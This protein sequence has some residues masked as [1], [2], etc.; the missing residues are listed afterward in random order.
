MK[1]KGKM[2]LGQA[3][4]LVVSPHKSLLLQQQVLTNFQH[5]LQLLNV[6]SYEIQESEFVKIL[7]SLVSHLNDLHR[8]SN[9]H[10][11]WKE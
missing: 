8:K 10:W 7:G 2:P 1:S 6:A 5:L 3:R 9:Q 4:T 11:H